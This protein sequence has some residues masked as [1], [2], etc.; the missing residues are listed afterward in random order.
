MPAR[1]WP[2][3]SAHDIDSYDQFVEFF[4]QAVMAAYA[5]QSDRFTIETDYF[6]GRLSSRDRASAAD[7]I[8]IRFGYRTLEN[9]DLA[10][11]VFRPDLYRKSPAHVQRWSGFRLRA[12]KW[13]SL[14]SATPCGYAAASTGT[15][16]WRT[17]HE[18]D[19]KGCSAPSMP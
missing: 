2:P 8:D 16:M 1:A 11:A 3:P 7:P 19:S 18:V 13:R 17:D 15:G 4:D 14:T 9:G 12:P 10:I 6:D 5:E